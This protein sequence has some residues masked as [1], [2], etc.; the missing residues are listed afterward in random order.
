MSSLDDLIV[1]CTA[2]GNEVQ[3]PLR[4]QPANGGFLVNPSFTRL[5]RHIASHLLD[6]PEDELEQQEAAEKAEAEAAENRV[7]SWQS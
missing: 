3:I 1:T 7:E 5:K 4:V 2:C 6:T